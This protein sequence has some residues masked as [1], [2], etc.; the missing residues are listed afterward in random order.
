MYL[1][2][3]V[4]LLVYKSKLEKPVLPVSAKSESGSPIFGYGDNTAVEQVINNE[5]NS[6]QNT[7]ILLTHITILCLCFIHC[8]ITGFLQVLF[9]SGREQTTNTA[10]L[11]AAGAGGMVQFWN[12]YGSGVLG[13]FNVFT[14][15]DSK[16][17]WRTEKAEL[18]SLHSIT[19]CRADSSGSTLLTGTSL[20][21][22]QVSEE[23]GGLVDISLTQTKL[24]ACWC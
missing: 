16:P 9:L 4:N 24:T 6:D 15:A 12:I 17:A 18:Q 21:Y 1:L 23:R 20:G 19:A 22:L 11:V 3:P 14:A 10:T 5:Q 2:I 7:V 13:Q 8:H